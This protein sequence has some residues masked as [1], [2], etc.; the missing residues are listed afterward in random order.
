MAG[1]RFP[2][3]YLDDEKQALATGDKLF[4]YD[5]AAG[6]NGIVDAANLTGAA[7]GVFKAKDGYDYRK[8]VTNTTQLYQQ[9]ETIEGVGALYPGYY[10]K[11]YFTSNQTTG[12]DAKNHL[13]III[14]QAI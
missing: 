12:S 10:I 2:D 6:R 3:D 4:I 8:K 5:A 13:V 1:K 7:S 9:G 14:S 11:A